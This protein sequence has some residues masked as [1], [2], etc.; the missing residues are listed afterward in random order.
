MQQYIA[1]GTVRMFIEPS[2]STTIARLTN[3]PCY[4]NDSSYCSCYTVKYYNIIQYNP[5]QYNTIQCTMVARRGRLAMQSRGGHLTRW[6]YQRLWIQLDD[7]YSPSMLLNLNGSLRTES[8]HLG[9]NHT[10][11]VVLLRCPTE[12]TQRYDHEQLT[13]YLRESEIREL[14]IMW[15]KVMQSY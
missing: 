1:V 10:S 5:I 12:T 15:E 11:V 6:W 2:A 8:S 9:R 3:S 13:S 4:S 7:Q 14:L